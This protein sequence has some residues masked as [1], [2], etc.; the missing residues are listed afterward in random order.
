MKKFII[1]LFL[2]NA[3]VF[4]SAN[5]DSNSTVSGQDV[6]STPVV[7]KANVSAGTE[8]HSTAVAEVKKTNVSTKAVS[9]PVVVKKAAVTKPVEHITT[10]GDSINISALVKS[11]LEA[12]QAGEIKSGT[13]YQVPE[14]KPEPAPVKAK[15]KVKKQEPG[16]FENLVITLNNFNKQYL[17]VTIFISGAVLILG[18]FFGRKLLKGLFGQSKKSLKKNIN[19]IRNEKPV[20]MK[21]K[22]LYEL[23]SKLA[24]SNNLY[25][26]SEEAIP[27]K[28]REMNVGEG[29][30][31][32]AAKIKAVQLS[33]ISK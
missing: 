3:A 6:Q 5:L 2:I 18:F 21:N 1:S 32:L 7:E 4:A 33:K 23:R 13:N 24:E 27:G 15:V 17:N 11:Q 25:G 12:A 26:M 22:K 20:Y 29:E 9:E 28:A 16:M 14:E 19:L 8:N 31:M 10:A 30:I